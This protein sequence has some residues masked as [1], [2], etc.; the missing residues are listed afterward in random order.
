MLN[1]FQRVEHDIDRNREE[2]ATGV[3]GCSE[4]ISSFEGLAKSPSMVQGIG[5]EDYRKDLE[6]VENRAG[7]SVATVADSV[8]QL[9]DV[10]CAA[11]Y[12]QMEIK[13]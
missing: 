10:V 8:P 5:L 1:F 11:P 12:C 3:K 6:A 13:R 2:L 9:E 7:R 4:R